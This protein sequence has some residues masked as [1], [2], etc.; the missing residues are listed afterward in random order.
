MSV[1]NSIA[2]TFKGLA[3]SAKRHSPEILIVSGIIG[4]VGTVVLACRAT[5]KAEAVVSE[6]KENLAKI[7]ECQNNVDSEKYSEEDAAND[8]RTVYIQTAVKIA[9]HYLPAIGLGALS[10]AGIVKSHDILSKRNVALAAAYVTVDTAFKEYRGRVREQ[11]G[12]EVENQLRYGLVTKEIEEKIIDEK[13]REK[14]VK[15]KVTVCE[16]GPS[17]YARFFEEGNPNYIAQDG[18]TM[19]FIGGQENY[20]N[21]L[22]RVNKI[23]YLNDVYRELGFKP[24]KAGAVVGWV[25]DKDGE[26]GDNYIRISKQWVDV[27]TES[28]VTGEVMYEKK[29]LLDFNVDGP[30]LDHAVRVGLMEA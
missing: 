7:E 16:G 23:V 9:G 21:D 14:T 11:F 29:L 1:L 17:E 27:P 18:P 12:D 28:V 15:K 13:G 24:S 30:I 20:L 10:L 3:A 6:A 26:E 22:L 5:L 2:A 19:L 25:Y 8:R 4:G